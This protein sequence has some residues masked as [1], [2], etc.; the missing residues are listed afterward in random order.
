MKHIRRVMSTQIGFDMVENAPAF[1]TRR[2]NHLD[3]QPI[4]GL[5][6]GVCP[7]FG[8]A[9]WDIFFEQDHVGRGRNR[10]QTGLGMKG[11]VFADTHLLGCHPG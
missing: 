7:C 2:L 1:I 10:D 8:C 9:V 3:R 6:H 5:L 4:Q 11:L